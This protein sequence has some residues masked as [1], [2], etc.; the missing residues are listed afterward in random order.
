MQYTWYAFRSY[1]I[2]YLSIWCI[3]VILNLELQVPLFLKESKSHGTEIFLWNKCIER[4][5]A[6]FTLVVYMYN[7]NKH[8]MLC[9]YPKCKNLQNQTPRYNAKLPLTFVSNI[10][11]QFGES[12]KVY[13]AFVF[14]HIALVN[15]CN[16]Y[17]VSKFNHMYD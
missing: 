4:V 12:F 16:F 14:K 11:T 2:L 17:Q 10:C 8:Y 6:S 13:Q 15:L 5:M 3:K 9:L 1:W 7:Y